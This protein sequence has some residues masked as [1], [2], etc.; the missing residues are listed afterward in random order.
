MSF[1]NRFE[2]KMRNFI[3]QTRNLL[4]ATLLKLLNF[5]EAEEVMQDAYL[6]VFIALENNE[7]IEPRPF[8][9]AVAKNMAISRLRHKQVESKNES[10]ISYLYK[11]Q[12][13]DYNAERIAEKNEQK[14]ELLEAINTL[15]VVC[16]QVF[17]MRKIKEQSHSEIAATMNISTKT[18]ENHIAKGMQLC[19]SYMIKKQSVTTKQVN[20]I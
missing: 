14:L 6:K 11:H 4:L 19:R 12:S 8:L 16:R 20:K 9:F 17:I 3:L 5:A 1:N 18:V 10:S 2:L 13:T 15:P 7:P